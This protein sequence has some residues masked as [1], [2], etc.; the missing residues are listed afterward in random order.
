MQN[1][2]SLIGSHLLLLIAT[3]LVAGS[4][5]ASEPLSKS[6]N[7]YSLTLM[8]FLGAALFL[9]PFVILN[10]SRRSQ[11]ISAFPRATV[12]SLFYCVFFVAFFEALKTTA[13]INTG[14]LFTLVPLFTAIFT[15]LLLK[16][17]LTKKLVLVYAM[18]A[19]G[20]IWIVSKGDILALIQGSNMV[21][22]DAIFM[23][24]VLAM[25]LYTVSMKW[26]YR[27]ENMYAFVF[28]II[29][30][31][32]LWMSLYIFVFDISLN[33]HKL[34]YDSYTNMAYLIIGATLITTVLYQRS[35]VV[36]GPERV[37]AYVFLNP[38][39]VAVITAI[40]QGAPI[41]LEILPGVLVTVLVTIVLQHSIFAITRTQTTEK[42]T[43]NICCSTK[44]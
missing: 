39:L 21:L 9:T 31:G 29:V 22:G 25:S 16:G 24:S 20:A 43:E 3:T 6:I 18:G 38:V 17:K 32:S 19:I 23:I 37:S 42:Q 35:A 1:R 13:P 36:L 5:V 8:R 4:F 41:Q 12:I 2:R 27:Q 10:H 7:P 40:F 44:C 26:L 34:N 30:A 15:A 11:V 33:W 28:C 14:S